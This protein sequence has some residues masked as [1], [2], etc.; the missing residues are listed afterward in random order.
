MS[1]YF[2]SL[3]FN[4]REEE[5]G[6]DDGLPPYENNT[7]TV[8]TTETKQCNID[9]NG[10]GITYDVDTVTPKYF[11]ISKD[12]LFF[13]EIGLPSHTTNLSRIAEVQELLQSVEIPASSTVLK[14]NKT[15]LFDD[16]ITSNTI[17]N[18][19]Y[20]G[21][22][23]IATLADTATTANTAILSN[24]I[25]VTNTNTNAVY[26]PTF[27]SGTGAGQTLRADSVT[28]F[29][30]VNPNTCEMAL[31]NTFGV[32][33]TLA[34]GRV[35]LGYGAGLTQGINSVALGN[36]AG[37]NAGTHCVAVGN[38]AGSDGQLVNAVAIGNG[39]GGENQ[40]ANA[41]AIGVSA[42]STNQGASSIAIGRQAGFS[43][44]HATSIVLNA[45]GNVLETTNASSLF[46]APIRNLT[47]TTA[48]LYNTTTKEVTYN[49]IVPSATLATTATN[50][51]TNTNSADSTQY[52]TFVGST[53]LGNPIRVDSNLTYN[54]F[55]NILSAVNLNVGTA[56]STPLI[57]NTGA[58]FEI[59][60]TQINL[61]ATTIDLQN[62]STTTTV[63]SQNAQIHA[64]SAG[65]ISNTF[66]KVKLNGAFIWIP[67]F[68]TDPTL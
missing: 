59:N 67:Y 39:A 54:P 47:N 10:F 32:N 42:G 63:G 58:T 64:N 18:V 40:A 28:T 33:G 56:I 43:N 51:S 2:E 50:V 52:V 36:N 41:I 22:S 25:D 1:A 38:F 65:L 45:T 12:G 49:S 8:T 44:Q 46:I 19:S 17:D 4:N 27:T 62:T 13:S 37:V 26:Y 16:G 20:T 11:T 53:T 14:I 48:L 5:I 30:S 21:R 29:W 60:A 34:T 55:Q 24:T 6:A 23:S 35:R 68:T 57:Q 31:G 15:I 3:L 61:D 66:L 7:F 9:N